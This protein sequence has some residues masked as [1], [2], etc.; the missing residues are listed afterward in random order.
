MMFFGGLVLVCIACVVV[1]ALFAPSDDNPQS[2]A[3]SET[4][5]SDQPVTDPTAALSPAEETT[6]FEP[7]APT[8]VP[9]VPSP[10]P[11]AIQPPTQAPTGDSRDNP[12]PAGVSVE[13]DEDMTLTIVSAIR[14]VNDIVKAGNSF[15]TEP[16][17][18]QEYVQVDVQVVCNKESSQ[19][20]NF[21]SFE[22]KAVG[23]DGNIHEVEIFVSGIDGMLESGDFFG[24]ATKSGKIFFL[25]PE[26]D[27]N[28]VIFWEPL[29]F[30][31]PVFLALPAPE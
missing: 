8:D 24:G 26:S 6:T 25:V 11:V 30:G 21:N 15:N 28:V 19:T 7:E 14:P 10:T 4:V 22:L 3:T 13:I 31:D 12:V 18:G 16:E 1:S 29:L 2:V 20:C 23:A 9:T 17:P 27:P 5:T